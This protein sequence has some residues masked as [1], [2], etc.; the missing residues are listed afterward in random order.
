MWVGSGSAAPSPPRGPLPTPGSASPAT[1]LPATARS[2]R[3]AAPRPSPAP[4]SL[5]RR[6]RTGTLFR[7]RPVG[8]PLWTREAGGGE[9]GGGA[10]SRPLAR[11]G[12]PSEG[13][14]LP[15]CD[16]PGG[17]Q[18]PGPLSSG[19]ACLPV[20]PRWAY[21]RLAEPWSSLRGGHHLPL[22]AVAARRRAVAPGPHPPILTAPRSFL[23]PV[24][25]ESPCPR[26]GKEAR[27][28]QV[29]HEAILSIREAQQELHRWAAVEGP[30]GGHGVRVQ[31]S[32]GW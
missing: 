23:T 3:A 12:A 27:R 24:G 21:Q 15:V 2:P 5:T 26:C 28:L 14:G 6:R 31:D 1:S 16:S 19:T 30:A 18:L 13:R 29:L 10:L 25:C 20:W 17:L 32:W 4:S 11:G 9:G 22:V 8:R 7:V